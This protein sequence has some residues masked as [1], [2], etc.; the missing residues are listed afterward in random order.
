M[1]RVMLSSYDLAPLNR[2][3]ATRGRERRAT[4]RDQRAYNPRVQEPVLIDRRRFGA[5]AGSVLASS[6]LSDACRRQDGPGRDGRI[7]ARPIGHPTTSAT[8]V[9]TLGLDA[10]RDAMLQ[11]PADAADAPLPLFVLLHGAGGSGEDVLQYLGEAAGQAGVAVLAPSSRGS[12]WDVLRGGFG[13]D[14]IFLDHALERVFKT[15]AVDPLRVTVGGFSDGA[16]YALSLGVINGDLFSRVVAFSPGFLVEGTPHGAPRFFISHGTAD[17]I[18]PID[19]CSRRIVPALRAR[20]YDVTFREFEGG[21]EVPDEI[22]RDGM[23]WAAAT[24]PA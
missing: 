21:H 24:A 13:G 9:R 7:T 10:S 14:V 15:V 20:G 1:P 16:S 18:L 11:V 5:I 4:R 17:S 2:S 3:R 23:H 6:A 12:T 8:G 22:A 19:R